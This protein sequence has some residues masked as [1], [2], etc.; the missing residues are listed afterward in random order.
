MP[1]ANTKPAPP[2]PPS[3]FREERIA[4]LDAAGLN[5]ILRDAAASEFQKAKA[6]VRAGELGDPSSVPALAALLTD[7]HLNTYARYGLEPIA[8]PSASQ[9]LRAA[10][11]KL[12]G[13]LLIGVVNS[14]GKRRDA[15][16]APALTKMLSS[17]NLPLARAAASALGSIGNEGAA[18][19]LKAAYPKATPPLKL[20]IA[21]A[22]LVC[23]ERLLAAGQRPAAFALYSWLSSP[24]MPKPMR[25]AAMNGI[26]RE[27]TSISRPR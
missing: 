21:D 9:A 2:T 16:A 22:S 4:Q 14:L 7:A 1:Q 12:Q 13:D 26:I 10:L 11:P 23:A 24:D 18:Q 5:A 15:L 25:L 20:A 19:S 27:E 3:E 17:S 6:C 8:D